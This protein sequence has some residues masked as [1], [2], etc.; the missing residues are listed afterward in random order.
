MGSNVVVEN[1][2]TCKNWCFFGFESSRG[3]FSVSDFSVEPFHLV[4]VS[5]TSYGYVA[6][7]LVLGAFSVQDSF[8]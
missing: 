5:A 6:N 1:L 3:F 2:I 7:M 4:V 8:L